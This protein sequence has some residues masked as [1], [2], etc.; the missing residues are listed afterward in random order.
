MNFFKDTFTINF[1][2]L[3]LFFPIILLGSFTYAQKASLGIHGRAND[4]RDI[5]SK[6]TAYSNTVANPDGTFTGNVFS[7]PI[8]YLKESSYYP[9]DLKITDN[10]SS[11]YLNF[12]FVNAT[13]SFKSYLPT[14]ISDGL[15]SEFDNNEIIRDMLNPKMYVE[16]NGIASDMTNM[17]QS[18]IEFVNDKAIFNN[19]YESINLSIERLIDSYTLL[20]IAL[21]LTNSIED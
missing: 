21:S 19:V 15:L 16:L 10:I 8:N 4:S 5:P 9:I 12:P 14:E 6:R 18:S 3:C 7:Y 2:K 17:S 11:K 20:N 13:N 1:V